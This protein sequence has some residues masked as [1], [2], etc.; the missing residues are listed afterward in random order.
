[1][2]CRFNLTH[3]TDLKQLAMR[4]TTDPDHKFELSLSLDDLDAALEIT[5]ANPSETKWR[6]VG[7]RALQAWKISLAEECFAA[8]GDLSA[9][10]LIYTSTG[11]T[12]GLETL[13]ARATE[14]GANNIAFASHLLL[15]QKEECIDVLL[16]TDRAPEAALFSRTYA[17]SLT[18]KTVD[19]WKSSLQQK[20][21]KIAD[22]LGHPEE[23]P[24]AFDE[25]WEESLEKERV[26]ASQ[27]PAITEA[28][29]PTEEEVQDLKAAIPTPE[30]VLSPPADDRSMPSKHVEI[31]L[32]L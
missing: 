13:A 17:P 6:S 16:K 20:N 30:I 5:R 32:Y 2:F 19:A 23:M 9:L 29:L 28:E 8:A 24:D 15:N 7:D 18:G 31:L 27:A 11:S 12:S 22:T 21:K 4:V 14:K 26:G 10:L 25:G 3:P 1:M